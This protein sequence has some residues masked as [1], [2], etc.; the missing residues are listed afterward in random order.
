LL[1][2]KGLA[3]GVAVP[4]GVQQS[5]ALLDWAEAQLRQSQPLVAWLDKYIA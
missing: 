1:K 2:R 3:V 4:E 5:P